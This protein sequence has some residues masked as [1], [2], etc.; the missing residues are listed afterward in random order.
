MTCQN[1][2]Q[3]W[4]SQASPITSPNS[5]WPQGS[6]QLWLCA[7]PAPGHARLLQGHPRLSFGTAICR[8]TPSCV[9]HQWTPPVLP[10]SSPL[11]HK[12]AVLCLDSTCLF[13][14]WERSNKAK[15][16]H[17]S[18]LFTLSNT[19]VFSFPFL[20]VP[21]QEINFRESMV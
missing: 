18:Y 17:R 6:V 3:S 7:T 2:I 11:L 20:E 15:M 21:F 13:S 12:I 5:A 9:L 16:G 4:C 14:G 8:I 19:T 10:S 1:T